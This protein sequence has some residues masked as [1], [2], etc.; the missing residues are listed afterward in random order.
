[1]N[2]ITPIY[3]A[4]VEIYNEQLLKKY[5]AEKARIK[6][7]YNLK[8]SIHKLNIKVAEKEFNGKKI[9]DIVTLQENLLLHMTKK[10]EY[11]VRLNKLADHEF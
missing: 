1:M 9:N 3:C 4:Q 7:G 5:L 11:P 10:Q 2:N 8:D 6:A